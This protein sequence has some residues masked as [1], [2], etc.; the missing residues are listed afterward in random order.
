MEICVTFV[1]LSIALH[2]AKILIIKRNF[3]RKYGHKFDMP[4]ARRDRKEP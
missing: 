1:V 4:D 2:I 3:E